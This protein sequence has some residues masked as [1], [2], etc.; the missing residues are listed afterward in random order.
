MKKI[1]LSLLCILGAVTIN[2]QT[3][4]I[5][6]AEFNALAGDITTT[7]TVSGLTLYGVS[8]SALTIDEN[9]KE[10]DG[11]TFTH[12]L[13]FN[14][15][16]KWDD[17]TTVASRVISF[18]VDGAKKITVYGMT[19]SSSS[20]RNLLF[21]TNGKQTEVGRFTHTGSAIGKYE[22]D[23]TGGAETIYVY[24]ESS[25]FNIYALIVES[26]TAINDDIKADKQV[27]STQYYCINGVM[28]STSFA[29][30]PKGI[31]IKKETYTDGTSSSTKISKTTAW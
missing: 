2:A 12:R 13:K 28:V 26:A 11:Y 18:A 9:G 29:A 22:F 3:W 27:A 30:L 25:G 8:G 14:G 21:T 31:Y 6:D 10:I 16:G 4:N 1:Y 24:S 23:Y 15:S 7:Q 17:E 20:E 19:S 5:S